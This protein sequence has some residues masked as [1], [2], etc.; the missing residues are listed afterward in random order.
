[1]TKKCF[2][3]F[4]S[5]DVQETENWLAQ[6]AG[7]GWRLSRI[8]FH[9]RAF[10]FEQCEPHRAIYRIQYLRVFDGSLSKGLAAS[11][12]SIVSSNRHWCVY[13]N[14]RE[15]CG[16][17]NYPTRDGVLSRNAKLLICA[18]SY[19]V[20]FGIFAFIVISIFPLIFSSANIRIISENFFSHSVG[21]LPWV[22]SSST[23]V[24]MF[25]TVVT[26]C[27]SLFFAIYVAVEMVSSNKRLTNE[28]SYAAL[29][30]GYFQ[31][32]NEVM[33]SGLKNGL[34]IKRSKL[35]WY[36]APDKTEAWLEEMAK[37]GLSFFHLAGNS[38]YFIK[39]T[40]INRRYCLDYQATVTKEYFDLHL[41]SGWN[42]LYTTQSPFQSKWTVWS[43]HVSRGEHAPDLYSD[44]T[45]NLHSI[46]RLATRN[47]M[48]Y[49]ATSLYFIFIFGWQIASIIIRMNSQEEVTTSV[50]SNGFFDP[51]SII[52]W[53]VIGFLILI[54]SIMPTY[55]FVQAI[56]PIRYYFRMKKKYGTDK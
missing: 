8:N 48:M 12:W 20:V 28:T 23:W 54:C 6:M 35:F 7:Q 55:F 45:D 46:R 34:I 33:S 44:K 31:K 2:R 50:A 25:I 1:M 49:F 42:L 14:S 15:S 26:L 5:F 30:H 37:R 19:F 17:Q 16:I 53:L 3:P 51:W 22:W 41:N 9:T 39:S 32:N 29:I 40:P 43:K 36:L 11:G 47:S 10:L 24:I 38:F 18:N 13:G 52:F 56:Q 4:W 27:I 21:I